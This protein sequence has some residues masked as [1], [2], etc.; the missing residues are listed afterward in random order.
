MMARRRIQTT[1]N[2]QVI[3]KGYAELGSRLRAWRKEQGLP[4]KH[5]A[6]DLGVSISVI[7][8]WERG[9][10]YPSIHN[11]QRIAD[12]LGIPLSM[13]FCRR[14]DCPYRKEGY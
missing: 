13:V 2:R 1:A 11:L 10:R 14:K 3:S 5:V 6:Q 9:H 8:Q 7:S 4:L 12:Y